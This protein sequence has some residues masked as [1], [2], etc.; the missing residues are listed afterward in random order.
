METCYIKLWS[1]QA[2]NMKPCYIKLWSPKAHSTKP[3]YIKLWSPQAHNMEPCYIKLWSSHAHNMKP[4]Y[5]KLWSPQANDMEPCYIKLWS[6]QTHNMEPCYIKLWSPQ[7]HN[8]IS[9]S[10]LVSTFEIHLCG[11]KRKLGPPSPILQISP[12]RCVISKE[13][14]VQQKW[15][16]ELWFR[17]QFST[18]LNSSALGCHPGWPPLPPLSGPAAGITCFIR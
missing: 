15:I 4:C 18:C 9:K 17:K 5:I 11:H 14:S 8:I 10:D 7:A 13:E 16:D 2:H 3:C 1:S 12:S 6:S